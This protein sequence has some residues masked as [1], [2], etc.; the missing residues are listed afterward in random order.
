MRKTECIDIDC[1]DISKS[2]LSAILRAIV[3]DAADDDAG[4]AGWQL[5]RGRELVSYKWQAKLRH[6]EVAEDECLK[7]IERV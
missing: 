2:D 4:R 3:I 6:V 1:G 7:E 5:G